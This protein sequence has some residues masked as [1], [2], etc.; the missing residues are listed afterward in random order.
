MICVFIASVVVLGSLRP[1]LADFRRGCW[2]LQTP[3]QRAHRM[4]RCI[5]G[6]FHFSFIIGDSLGISWGFPVTINRIS[7]DIPVLAGSR[8][9]AVKGLTTVI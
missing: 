4:S 6:L 7:R 9:V 8:P 5:I 2:S 1:T 3:G